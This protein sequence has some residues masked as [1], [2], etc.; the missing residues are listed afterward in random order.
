[1]ASDGK[2]AIT[3]GTVKGSGTTYTNTGI[4]SLPAII[5]VVTLLE[6]SKL[7]STE[8]V[9]ASHNTASADGDILI[10]DISVTTVLGHV[11]NKET[12]EK[13]DDHKIP[14]VASIDVPKKAVKKSVK[15]GEGVIK[16]STRKA[17]GVKDNKSVKTTLKSTTRLSSAK[18]V[19]PGVDV[20]R[21]RTSRV[22]GH[23]G[24]E[25]DAKKT[26]ALH[27]LVKGETSARKDGNGSAPDE[28]KVKE[29][30]SE[31]E[32]ETSAKPGD[33]NVLVEVHGRDSIHDHAKTNGDH[34]IQ[35]VTRP[36]E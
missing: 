1:M 2:K 18:V 33:G 4:I 3:G 25:I 14:I 13:N 6:T 22:T 35:H 19:T 8:V 16:S 28:D 10:N 30:P 5:D 31:D 12:I 7:V 15:D 26:D 21:G 11:G 34:C 24:V 17:N 23:S 29:T 32:T 27:K 20:N 9:D 36:R